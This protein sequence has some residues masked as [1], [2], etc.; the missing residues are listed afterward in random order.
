MEALYFSPLLLG[1]NLMLASAVACTALW[2]FSRPY[3]GPGVWTS[4]VWTLILGLLLFFGYMATGSPLL[5]SVSS[6][7]AIVAESTS[8]CSASYAGQGT[9]R[10]IAAIRDATR[11]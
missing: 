4:G 7:A 11:Q 5:N 8:R 9:E 2:W 1:I 3:R 10:D 6:S